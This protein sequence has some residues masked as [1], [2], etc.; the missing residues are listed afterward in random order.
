MSVTVFGQSVACRISSSD[1]LREVVEMPSRYVDSKIIDHID[2]LAERFIAASP[3][4]ILGT[5]RSDGG[6]DQT[7]RGDPPGF[8]KVLDPKTLALPDRPGNKRMDAMENIFNNTAVGLI[9]MIPGHGDTLRVSGQGAVIQDSGLA[10]RLAVNGRPAGLVTLIRVER[11][12]CHCPK[13]FIR[14]RAWQS[15]EWPDTS[16]VPSLAEMMKA[17]GKLGDTVSEL[18]DVIH[19]SNTEK[20]Y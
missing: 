5:H 1:Q 13:A 3:L 8:V 20:L 16:D 4:A 10:E 2:P 7:P 15:D 14:S 18:Q 12:L 9:F 6:V 11:V 19:H 17:H